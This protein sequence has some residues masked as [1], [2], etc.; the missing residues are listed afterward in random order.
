MNNTWNVICFLN[1]WKLTRQSLSWNNVFL[2]LHNQMLADR[3]SSSS[4][5][6]QKWVWLVNFFRWS[7]DSSSALLAIAFK[8]QCRSWSTLVVRH[9]QRCRWGKMIF[10]RSRR[11]GMIDAFQKK[12]RKPQARRCYSHPTPSDICSIHIY[13]TFYKLK[14]IC[15]LARS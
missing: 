15:L 5:L 8:A 13:S 4:K 11:W 9:L 14:L 7:E 6:A 1:E 3:R 2:M 10:G 12:S